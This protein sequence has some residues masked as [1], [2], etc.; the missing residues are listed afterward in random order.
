M[1][2][3]IISTLGIIAVYQAYRHDKYRQIADD[4]YAQ[5][6]AA[7]QSRDIWYNQCRKLTNQNLELEQKLA[8]FDRPRCPITGRFKPLDKPQVKQ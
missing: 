5:V 3:L 7:E 4:L 2:T 1:T 6:E 8:K